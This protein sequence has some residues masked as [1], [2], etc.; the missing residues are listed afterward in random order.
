MVFRWM[1]FYERP[2]PK[3]R[4]FTSIKSVGMDM[5]DVTTTKINKGEEKTDTY[6]VDLKSHYCECRGWFFKKTC[7]HIREVLAQLKDKGKIIQF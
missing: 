6:R 4:E 2:I 3:M 5:Y 1:D 7:C